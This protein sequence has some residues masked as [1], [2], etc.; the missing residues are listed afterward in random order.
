MDIVMPKYCADLKDNFNANCDI[1][2]E[3]LKSCEDKLVG[4]KVNVR[5]RGL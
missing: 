3:R 5:K 1:I 4:I 2:S